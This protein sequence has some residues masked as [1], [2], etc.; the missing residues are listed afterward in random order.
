MR[1]KYNDLTYKELQ[2]KKDEL[3]K[4]LK[5]LRFNKI[6]GHIDNPVEIRNVKR[7]ISRVNTILHEFDL[8]IRQRVEVE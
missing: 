3:K 6:V 4:Q 8:G 1:D 5:D 2:V 7:R